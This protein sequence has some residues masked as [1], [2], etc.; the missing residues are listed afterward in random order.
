[1][2]FPRIAGGTLSSS[3]A[4]STNWLARLLR[5]Q[6]IHAAIVALAV[7][8]LCGFVMRDFGLSTDEAIYIKNDRHLADWFNDFSEVGFTANFS[9]IRLQEVQRNSQVI[10]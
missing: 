7:A 3:T 4:P 10:S 5:L 6:L 2:S 8:I 9:K 1:M